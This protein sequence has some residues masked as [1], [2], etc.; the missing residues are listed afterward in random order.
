[1][2]RK[3]ATRKPFT[4]KNKHYGVILNVTVSSGYS[5][6]GYRGT[7]GKYIR[8]MAGHCWIETSWRT[9]RTSW[10]KQKQKDGSKVRAFCKLCV[11]INLKHKL[12]VCAFY[13][14]SLLFQ[15]VLLI[16]L[17]V[18]LTIQFFSYISWIFKCKMT[19]YLKFICVRKIFRNTKYKASLWKRFNWLSILGS[20]FKR[21][22]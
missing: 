2:G 22:S 7:K 19:F 9:S 20:S 10:Q 4:T 16:T 17:S 11:F 12:N 18:K 21:F 15:A 5:C 14:I 1:M 8:Q 3:G 6:S 13:I